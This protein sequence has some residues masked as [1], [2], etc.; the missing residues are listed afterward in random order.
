MERYQGIKKDY[1]MR[2]KGERVVR[3]LIYHL[4]KEINEKQTGGKNE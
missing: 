4:A 3:F 2:L 1:T